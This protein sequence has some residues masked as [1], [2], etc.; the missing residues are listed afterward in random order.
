MK[1]IK[2][3]LRGYVSLSSSEVF[4][5]IESHLIGVASTVSNTT[6]PRALQRFFKK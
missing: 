3:L 4:D 2:C 1:K 5:W 6:R